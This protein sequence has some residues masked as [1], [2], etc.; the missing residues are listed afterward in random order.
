MSV[1]S[2]LR[3]LALK[4]GGEDPDSTEELLTWAHKFQR[5]EDAKGGEHSEAY[6]KI[7]ELYDRMSSRSKQF[8]GKLIQDD[9]EKGKSGDTAKPPK[10]PGEKLKILKS[11]QEDETDL[12]PDVFPRSKKTPEDVEEDRKKTLDKWTKEK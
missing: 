10:Q 7:D 1:M 12:E 8:A 5:D 2:E 3:E 6:G 4:H 11:R 9:K